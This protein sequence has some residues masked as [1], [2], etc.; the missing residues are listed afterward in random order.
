MEN[1][2]YHDVVNRHFEIEVDG[3]AA[4]IEYQENLNTFVLN[5]THIPEQLLGK[6]VLKR[7]VDAVIHFISG[8]RY[9]LVPVDIM[10]KSYLHYHPECLVPLRVS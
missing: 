5:Y 6:G 2:V 8:K 3:R 9:Q 4:Y 7:L 10:F 1:A